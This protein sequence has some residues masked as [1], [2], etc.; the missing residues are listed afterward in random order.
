MAYRDPFNSEAYRERAEQCRIIAETFADCETRE[1]ML[2]IA[3]D[4]ERLA[5]QFDDAARRE[6]LPRHQ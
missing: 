2:R 3:A 5:D 4:Y 1:A 6:G